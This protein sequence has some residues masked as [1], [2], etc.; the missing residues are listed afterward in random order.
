MGI[1]GTGRS[2]VLIDQTMVCEASRLLEGVPSG[3][4]GHVLPEGMFVDE[5]HHIFW[6][7]TTAERLIH[8]STLLD[9]I[10]LYDRVYVLDSGKP[11]DEASLTLRRVLFERGILTALDTRTL[12]MPVSAELTQFLA[13]IVVDRTPE[14]AFQASPD[15]VGESIRATLAHDAHERH[16]GPEER[17]QLLG[18]LRGELEGSP[19]HGGL[20][21]YREEDLRDLRT[22]PVGTLGFELLDEIG[23]FHSGG[24]IGGVSHLRTFVYWRTAAHLQLPF[25]PSLRRL[26]TYHLLTEHI[27]NSVQERVYNAVGEAFHCAVSEVYE[28]ERPLPLYLPPALSLFL[29]HL[30]TNGNIASAIDDLRR[31]H[32]KLRRDLASFQH[33]LEGCAT[34]RD[35]RD[36]RRRLA[37][38]LT[39]L[40]AEPNGAPPHGAIDQVLD[41]V[42]DAV[43]AAANPL[44]V[45]G[46]SDTLIRRPVE[47]IRSWW[48]RRPIRS[49]F[50][51]S[52]RLLDLSQYDQLLE[53]ATGQRCS[54]EQITRLHTQYGQCL[55]LYG[56]ETRL[57]APA[58]PTRPPLT[59]SD[60]TSA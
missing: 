29:D 4:R 55:A 11:A 38:A 15:F 46:Y 20:R 50:A 26:P 5:G 32:R 42:P 49:A 45:S 7:P 25:I 21:F 57:P 23:R 41:I 9:A 16:H 2:A 59:T 31:S 43:R 52:D 53:A 51:L 17:Q 39:A 27:R 56:G 60:G 22:D 48:V 18:A 40:R 35:A 47:W 1:S 36:A 8:L 14:F 44:D 12:A 19:I 34:L 10:L 3:Y 13:D 30:R 6:G 33:A 37:D 54:S 58:S 28:N 24:L